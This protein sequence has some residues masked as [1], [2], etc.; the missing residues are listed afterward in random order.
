VSQVLT[1]EDWNTIMM[2]VIRASNW[3]SSIFFMMWVVF[4]NW[5]LLTLFLAV[6]MEAFEGKYDVNEAKTKE[7]AAAH[8]TLAQRLR[9]AAM[10]Q[11]I[12]VKVP[13]TFPNPNRQTQPTSQCLNSGVRAKFRVTCPHSFS[14]TVSYAFGATRIALGARNMSL[15]R[16]IWVRVT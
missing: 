13:K 5:I 14:A 12:R 15:S 3:Y 6:V 1:L 11:L 16:P 4:G 7:R 10:R 9:F 8:H 2:A